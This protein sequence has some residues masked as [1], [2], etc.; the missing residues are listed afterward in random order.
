MLLAGA[1]A[2]VASSVFCLV[3][4]WDN[5]RVISLFML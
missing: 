3:R 2:V 5:G 4:Y 1:G